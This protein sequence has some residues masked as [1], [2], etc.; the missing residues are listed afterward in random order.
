MIDSLTKEKVLIIG[1]IC[2]T[3]ISSI[4]YTLPNSSMGG[5]DYKT[6]LRCFGLLSV[7]IFSLSVPITLCALIIFKMNDSI[8][9]SWRKFTVIYFFIHTFLI[10][11]NP[12]SRAEFS[13]FEKKTCFLILMPI[14]F[15]T[16]LA[17]IAY[18]SYQLRGK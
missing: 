14:Y 16:S 13:P 11:V 5:C 9:Y 17:I 18:K 2:I 15:L 4:I 1:I 8:F 10:I 7:L 12:W 3:A 6:S